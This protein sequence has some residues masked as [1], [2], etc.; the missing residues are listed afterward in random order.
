MTGAEHLD[1]CGVAPGITTPDRADAAI[2][3]KEEDAEGSPL[4]HT[5]ST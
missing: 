4:T 1:V 5:P 2:T 3:E